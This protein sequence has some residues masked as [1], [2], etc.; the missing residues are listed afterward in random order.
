MGMGLFICQSIV[1][2]YGGRLWATDAKPHGA[3]FHLA[4]PIG[5]AIEG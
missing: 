5:E 4:L 1:E 2:A 3:I